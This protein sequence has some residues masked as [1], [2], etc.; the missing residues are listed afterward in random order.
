MSYSS[1]LVLL[2]YS[3]LLVLW[4]FSSLPL[5]LRYS[6]LLVLLSYS[7]LP[8]LLSHSLL[9]VLLS[10]SLLLVLLSYS[11]IPVLLSLSSRPVLLSYSFLLVLLSLSLL[12]VQCYWLTP[13]SWCHW[14]TPHSRCC[15]ITPRSWYYWVFAAHTAAMQSPGLQSESHCMLR[16]SDGGHSPGARCLPSDDSTPHSSYLRRGEY[17]PVPGHHAR[18]PANLI[19]CRVVPSVPTCDEHCSLL[20]EVPLSAQTQTHLSCLSSLPAPWHSDIYYFLATLSC[21]RQSLCV[22]YNHLTPPPTHW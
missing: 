15:W 8:V 10:Y 16:A 19:F 22:K 11:S 5:L 1:L 7:S 20:H 14:V 4:S 17:C 3:L 21:A 2:S 18:Y 12:P 13:C 6:S 9:L